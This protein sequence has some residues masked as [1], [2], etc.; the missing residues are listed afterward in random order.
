MVGT[1]H[2]YRAEGAAAERGDC[3]AH[4]GHVFLC[5]DK[6]GRC[7]SCAATAST[8]GATAIAMLRGDCTNRLSR[9]ART[10]RDNGS[11]VQR[12]PD[13]TNPFHALSRTPS[14]QAFYTI[15]IKHLEGAK[16]LNASGGTSFFEGLSTGCDIANVFPGTGV[17]RARHTSDFMAIQQVEADDRLSATSLNPGELEL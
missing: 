6:D 1:V 4:I 9:G 7:R 10:T 5:G 11:T 8:A 16:L 14:A 15:F 17:V 3:A 2:G 13:R 12:V